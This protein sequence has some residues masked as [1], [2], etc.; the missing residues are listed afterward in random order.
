MKLN[1][2]EFFV[3]ELMSFSRVLVTLIW[4][5][6]TASACYT[7]LHFEDCLSKHTLTAAQLRHL[8]QNHPDTV[9][10]ESIQNEEHASHAEPYIHLG[11]HGTSA[12]H[13]HRIARDGFRTRQRGLFGARVYSTPN[14]QEAIYYAS[15]HGGN[16]VKSRVG[17]SDYICHVLIRQRDLLALRP[18]DVHVATLSELMGI[19]SD[20][21]GL[22][23][24]QKY[25]DQILYIHFPRWTF[26]RITFPGHTEINYPSSPSWKKKLHVFCEPVMPYQ[27]PRDAWF[28]WQKI[29]RRHFFY[30]PAKV[31]REFRHHSVL[32]EL[33]P[34]DLRRITSQ[35]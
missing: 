19:Q 17:E 29:K 22:A 34:V 23:L 16:M 12:E 35:Q 6:F 26:P 1:H 4:L 15:M 8:A 31:T 28:R 3:P 11:Y 33:K 9:L 27:T 21:D 25:A 7:G 13:I 18:M 32:G 10:S 5:L 20:V 24:S 2:A 14:V 30:L